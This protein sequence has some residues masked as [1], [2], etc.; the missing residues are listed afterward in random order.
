MSQT[1]NF[2]NQKFDLI[3]FDESDTE[4]FKCYAKAVFTLDWRA[5]CQFSEKTRVYTHIDTFSDWLDGLD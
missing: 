1:N 5:N 3:L 2:L 4:G